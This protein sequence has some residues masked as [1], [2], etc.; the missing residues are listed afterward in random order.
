M[1]KELPISYNGNKEYF[2]TLDIIKPLFYKKF[3]DDKNTDT[4]NTDTKNTDKIIKNLIASIAEKLKKMNY[5][6]KLITEKLFETL[7][8]ILDKIHD[9]EIIINI[10][11]IDNKHQYKTI[12]DKELDIDIDALLKQFDEID[13]KH[14]KLGGK[15]TKRRRKRN[16]KSHK[17]RSSFKY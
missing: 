15:R 7:F 11:E 13:Q 6:K 10:K 8:I 17:K 2:D 14:G 5:D 12:V 4:K 1:E 16:K 9:D 3:E